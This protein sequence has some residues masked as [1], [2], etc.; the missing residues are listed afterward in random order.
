MTFYIIINSY[1]N[2]LHFYIGPI[3]DRMCDIKPICESLVGGIEF[4][5]K[6]KDELQCGRL[7]LSLNV[8]SIQAYIRRYN[9][10]G[11]I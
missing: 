7:D 6:F 9:T 1:N 2:L 8:R 10:W 5:E 11:R 4:Y 3:K